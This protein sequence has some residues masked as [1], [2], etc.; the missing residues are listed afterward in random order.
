MNMAA[1]GQPGAETAPDTTTTD[2]PEGATP[3][4]TTTESQP[5]GLDRLYDR[6]D[7]MAGQQR[8]MLESLQ[9]ALTP[10]EEAEA[11]LGPEDYYT[12][13]GDL[14]E[15]GARALIR[16]LVNEQV[17]A[18]LAP[19]EQAR[20]VEQRDDAY[21]ALKEEYPELKDERIGA[22]IL[23]RA[24]EWANAV[25][26][27]MIERPE[28]VDVIEAFYK[29]DRYDERATQEAAELP[30]PVVL[31]SAQGGRPSVRQSQ[32]PDWQKRVIEAAQRDA[33]RI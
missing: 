31:E 33:P 28:F 16:D 25:D 20:Q 22:Q 15:D 12:E 23:N 26:P 2:A 18:Q 27:R 3:E 9:R 14:T 10:E 8:Q 7:Q 24:V 29:A 5:G 1:Q 4:T 11:E 19:R 6:M 30:R 32:E 13:T 17:E 21:E